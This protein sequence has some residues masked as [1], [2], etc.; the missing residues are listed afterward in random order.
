MTVSAYAAMA[1]LVVFPM[2]LIWAAM[3]DLVTMKIGNRL[4]ATLLVAYAVLA[5]LAGIGLHH[6]ALSAAMAALVFFVAFAIFVLG[7]VG[8]GD[9]KLATITALWLG[10]DHVLMYVVY[11]A[12]I[13]GALTLALLVFRRALIPGSWYHR[14]WIARLHAGE[15]GVPYGVALATAGLLVFPETAWMTAMPR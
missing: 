15:T 11:T 3:A 7:W 4:V 9:A 13:G 6:L 1:A 10:A 5:P 8:G 14:T 12:L 2:L